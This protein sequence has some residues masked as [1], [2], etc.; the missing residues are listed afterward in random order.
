VS[1]RDDSKPTVDDKG[2]SRR[3]ST[4]APTRERERY[5][6][7]AEIARGGMGRVV[8]AT[9][10][11]L[12]RTVALKEALST[13]PE[14]L[15]RFARETKITARLEH[16][17]IVPLYD[18]GT[19]RD[20][21]PY[22]VMRKVSGRPLEELVVA[23]RSLAER[24]RLLPH[25]VAAAQALAH[26]HQRKVVHR[27]L[28]PS[29]ILVGDLGETVVID[30][31]LAKV[32]GEDDDEHAM[33]PRLDAGASMKTRIGTVFGTP[34][35]M[36][37]E[38]LRG[39]PVDARVDVY[40]LGATLYF[41]LARQ[42]PHNAPSGDEM[43]SAA[44]A[45]PPTPIIEVA[46]GVPRELTTIVDK[47]LSFREAAR[48]P[49]AGA[50]AEDLGRFLTGQ[51]V[52][53]HRYSSRERLVRFVRRHRVSVAVVTLAVI[54]LAA[55][56]TVG[57]L[58][59]LAERDRAD[60]QAALATQGQ[61]DA[62][63]RADQLLLSQAETLVASN[64]TAAV[65]MLKQLTADPVRRAALWREVRAIAASAR[66]AGIA[67]GI[68]GPLQP[69]TIELSPGGTQAVV[70]GRDGSIWTYD[71]AAHRAR[72]IT[73]LVPERLAYY[74][75]EDQLAIHRE[76]DFTF[77]NLTTGARRDLA[78][79]V[80]VGAL[81]IGSHRIFM[82]SYTAR[83]L[84]ELPLDA[85][86]GEEL[87]RVL[88][89][90]TT[91][92][93]LSNDG[94]WLAVVTAKRVAIADVTQP[95][96]AFRDLGPGGASDVAWS[97][98]ARRLLATYPN[99]ID[100]F[101]VESGQ[102]TSY[103]HTDFAFAPIAL[104]NNFM[105]LSSAGGI[106]WSQSGAIAT[107]YLGEIETGNGLHAAPENRVVASLGNR[108]IIL[109]GIFDTSI[110]APTEGLTRVRA[111]PTS[112][113]LVAATPG[114][115]LYWDLEQL[116]PPPRVL[117]SEVASFGRVGR[118]DFVVQKQDGE[119]WLLDRGTQQQHR[120]GTLP[121]MSAMES[122]V[123]RD[124]L[125]FVEPAGGA[126][127]LFKLANGSMTTV[128]DRTV[129]GVLTG[130]DGVLLARRGGGLVLV[131]ADLKR[132][133]TLFSHGSELEASAWSPGWY[134]ASY[135]DGLIWRQ[136]TATRREETLRVSPP[137]LHRQWA[138]R[139]QPD[140]KLF[141]P[142]DNKVMCWRPDGA[143]VE[144]V[145]LPE[146]IVNT[147]SG[148]DQMIVITKDGGGY[149]VRFDKPGFARSTIPAGARRISMSD[150]GLAVF[151]TAVSTPE[152]VDLN[153]AGR[154]PVLR[155]GRQGRVK[156]PTISDDGKSIMALEGT[157]LVEWPIDVPQDADA[158]AAWLDRLTNATAELGPTTLTWH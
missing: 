54:A 34:G 150:S 109:E 46:P 94:R 32:L 31:G 10:T 13:D 61:R 75:G 136:N 58:R 110:I 114:R 123:A 127:I 37:P 152:I 76:R 151:E 65:A 132:R 25:V 20:G 138:L 91:N 26:A 103:P 23:A 113:Y 153:A 80:P 107:R 15:R 102:R 144:H 42:P 38:Q 82:T 63:D 55:G 157:S 48:Y 122:N 40:A 19:S 39:E 33:Q 6:S 125:L 130:D 27:D 117:A 139:L 7:G 52:A 24:L 108:M 67:R 129:F 44:A 89:G 4:E 126:A 18:A 131:D 11:L 49:D 156:S 69:K 90:R 145:V 62:Q 142:V 2:R 99:R 104:A 158:T 78:L 134:A 70:S 97:P 71:L 56:G 115:L 87:R 41:M 154:W 98:D 29:N 17:S 53:S 3:P 35:F 146:T 137:K 148:N 14:A 135:L 93:Q 45:G 5:A 8:E 1:E 116:M 50:F 79:P 149:V 16:P 121:P 101:D 140:G 12:G 36:S 133:R 73:Q 28:K 9:D 124:R 84:Y 112:R 64:P 106:R 86:R 68:T 77:W 88:P 105:F 100:V 21:S 66:I 141:F 22:Y 43:M 72:Q 85:T 147:Y 74:I 83:E 111:T 128:D 47:A 81:M 118:S 59:V 96:I 57:V 120:L 60:A 119:W 95:A 155:R 143:L 30:W 92:A 51:L